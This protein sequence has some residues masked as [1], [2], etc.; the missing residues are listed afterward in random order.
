MLMPREAAVSRMGGG[1]DPDGCAV[2]SLLCSSAGTRLRSLP[3]GNDLSKTLNDFPG[4]SPALMLPL[5]SHL[6]LEPAD[7]FPKRLTRP[8]ILCP[9]QPGRAEPHY[10][11][12]SSGLRQLLLRWQPQ[13]IPRDA[14]L[15]LGPARQPWSQ[16]CSLTPRTGGVSSQGL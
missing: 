7:G 12:S 1:G 11:G 10:P 5:C 9:R 6:T 13:S 8:R 3:P 14:S 4:K 2:T 16:V 15:S